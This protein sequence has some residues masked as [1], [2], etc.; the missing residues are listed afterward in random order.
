MTVNYFEETLCKV[1]GEKHAH[2][3]TRMITE[4]QLNFLKK[5]YIVCRVPAVGGQCVMYMVCKG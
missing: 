5:K 1:E 2:V 3:T 4:E